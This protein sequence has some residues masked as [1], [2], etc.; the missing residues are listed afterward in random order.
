MAAVDAV[1]VSA[2]FTDGLPSLCVYPSAGAM[3]MHLANDYIHPYRS[4]GALA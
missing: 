4:T 3:P 1:D 2:S